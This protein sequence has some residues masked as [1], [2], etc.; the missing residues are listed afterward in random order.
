VSYFEEYNNNNELQ[1]FYWVQNLEFIIILRVVSPNLLLV[2]S[3]CVD[4]DNVSY[5]R[6]KLN[7]YRDGLKK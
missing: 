7:K 2:T 5:F 1:Y 3:Y 6:K 4:T